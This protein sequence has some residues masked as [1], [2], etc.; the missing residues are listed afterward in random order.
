MMNSNRNYLPA[1][2]DV[3]RF[4]TQNTPGIIR[5]PTL[6]SKSDNANLFKEVGNWNNSNVNY[7]KTTFILLYQNNILEFLSFNTE[8]SE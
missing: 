4:L 2:F 7:P 6:I 8:K 1:A 5:V 3:P